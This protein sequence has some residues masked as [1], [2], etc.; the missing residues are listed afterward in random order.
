LLFSS[1]YKK[2]SLISSAFHPP[3]IVNAKNITQK[4]IPFPKRN[5]GICDNPK[6]S[7]EIAMKKSPENSAQLGLT[8]ILYQ[9]D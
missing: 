3:A 1:N 2:I 4:V 6:K 7:F 5:A 9:Q 8:D